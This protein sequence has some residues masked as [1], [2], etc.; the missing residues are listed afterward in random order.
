MSPGLRRFFR[1]DLRG[2]RTH[3][4]AW[5][6]SGGLF[7]LFRSFIRGPVVSVCLFSC[8]CSVVFCFFRAR[9]PGKKPRGV[10][11]KMIIPKLRSFYEGH[12]C[13]LDGHG[14][15]TDVGGPLR[16]VLQQGE[17]DQH[18]RPIPMRL[19]D[20]VPDVRIQSVEIRLDRMARTN[21]TTDK[22]PSCGRASSS[23]SSSAGSTGGVLTDSGSGPSAARGTAVS[24]GP[25]HQSLRDSLPSIPGGR[26]LGQNAESPQKSSL[27]RW[28]VCRYRS[29]LYRNYH[30]GIGL[31]N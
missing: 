22:N 15:A 23:L 2:S 21:K 25:A 12:C 19:R 28:Q 20:S 14:P 10:P 9:G 8:C 17:P 7:C 18:A 4:H 11:P 30:T 29:W 3:R 26:E 31:F 27:S 6:R 5:P 16:R 24:P 13:H 1:Q